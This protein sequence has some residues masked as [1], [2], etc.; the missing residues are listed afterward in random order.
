MTLTGIILAG[1]N[2]TRFGSDKGLYLVQ[3]KTLI[4][5]ATSLL[6]SF[7]NEIIISSNNPGHAVFGLRVIADEVC[8]RGPM[9]GIYS[10]L[11][12]SCTVGNLVIAVD[13]IRVERDFFHYL[14]N[15]DL[16]GYD[17][18]VPL[19]EKRYFEPLVG[20]YSKNI[21]PLMCRMMERDILKLPVM[22]QQARV[23]KLEV[24]SDFA[25]YYPHYFQ[26]LNTP[27]A[28]GLRA[29]TK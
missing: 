24:E 9:M 10:A 12:A 21:L 13:N 8:S 4:E 19:L 15:H 6:S 25:G 16:T 27:G 29:D 3:G 17:A 2:N 11:K 14:L 5:W 28:I 1:G 23:L 22:L 20:F 26:S 7:C 18:A